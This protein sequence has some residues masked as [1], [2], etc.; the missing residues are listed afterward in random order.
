MLFD[1][2]KLDVRVLWCGATIAYAAWEGHPFLPIHLTVF[3][4]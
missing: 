3:T 4:N 1:A 2:D